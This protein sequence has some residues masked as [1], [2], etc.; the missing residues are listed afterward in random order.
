MPELKALVANQLDL[1]TLPIP[2]AEP[3]EVEA[4]W[5][6]KKE[7]HTPQQAEELGLTALNALLIQA[8]CAPRFDMSH[9]DAI[10]HPKKGAAL[11]RL[12]EADPSKLQQASTHAKRD[13]LHN[14]L[15]L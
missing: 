15:G 4:Y 2:L 11:Q 5:L 9:F 8:V 14:D 1:S 12:L 7:F 3:E 13:K 6:W 10:A